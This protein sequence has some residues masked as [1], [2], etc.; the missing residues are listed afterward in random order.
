MHELSIAIDLVELAC[1]ELARLGS[2]RVDALHL[3]MGPLCGVV[4]DALLFAFDVAAADTRLEGATLKIEEV[5]LTVWCSQCGTEVVLDRT[6]R[7]RCPVCDGT[8]PTIVRGG[9]LELVAL[10]VTDVDPDR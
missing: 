10:E 2:V 9:E 6:Q 7:R 3:R 4:K 1:D 5:P 8:T